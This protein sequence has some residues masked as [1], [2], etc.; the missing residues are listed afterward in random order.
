[1]YKP[2]KSLSSWIFYLVTEGKKQ[3]GK[4]INNKLLNIDSYL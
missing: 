3:K 4:K 2:E 1:M